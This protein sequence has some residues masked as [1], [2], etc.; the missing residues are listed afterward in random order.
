MARAEEF[1]KFKSREEALSWF[2]KINSGEASDED[3]KAHQAWLNARDQNIR[4]YAKLDMVWSDLDVIEDPRNKSVRSDTA[5]AGSTLISRRGFIV[6]GAIAASVAAII[7][8]TV[9]PAFLSNDYSTSVGEQ[10]N[11]TLADGSR[12][13]LDADTALKL[14]FTES[15]RRLRLVRGRAF[16]DVAKD[17]SR[18]FIVEAFGGSV[19]AL[20]TRFTVHLWDED[21]TVSVEESAVAVIAP[22]K[23]SVDVSEKHTVSYDENNLTQVTVD[24]KGAGADWRNGKL[25]F[26]DQP[27]RQVVADINRYRSGVI[28]ITDDTLFELRVSGIFDIN[29]LDGVLDAIQYSLPVQTMQLT[30]YVILLRPAG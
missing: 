28:Y 29:N 15:E 18:A 4:E 17:K 14:E 8:V 7:A 20:G 16:F 5:L 6:G 12:I 9:V 21:V 24:N 10:R 13:M 22:N 30:P 11:I 1:S 25:L 19:T 26:E 27:L 2:V 23:E 3:Y